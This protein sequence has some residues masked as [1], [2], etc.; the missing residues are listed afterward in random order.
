V[1]SL[2]LLGY[3]FHPG[4][5][6]WV[7][8]LTK[9]IIA[10]FFAG[11]PLASGLALLQPREEQRA[12]GGADMI[13]PDLRIATA[14]LVLLSLAV[15]A[16]AGAGKGTDGPALRRLLMPYQ[17]EHDVVLTVSSIEWGAPDRWS[18]TTRYVRMLERKA[19]RNVRPWLNNLSVTLSP[20]TAGSR[21]GIGYL[22]IYSPKTATPESG[23]G[24]LCE[25]RAVLL[26][27]WGDP[28]VTAADGTFAGGEARLSL[29]GV[30]VVGV[31]HYSR[32]SGTNAG[33]GSFWGYHVGVGM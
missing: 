1:V 16:S 22:G 27:T 19:E 32:V 10:I 24:M 17:G 11:P 7:G 18:F 20:G 21:L 33:R 14:A 8:L 28:L 23:F 6:G 29:Q 12:R 13:R 26:R 9:L 30:V 15:P 25:A 3:Y 4:H 5:F 2:F 31:G